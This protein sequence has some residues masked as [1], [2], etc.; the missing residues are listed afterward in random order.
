MMQQENLFEEEALPKGWISARCNVQDDDAGQRYVFIDEVWT[1]T[2]DLADS[3]MQRFVWVNIY[4]QHCAT[5]QQIS[6]GIG[7][8]LRAL[9][10]WV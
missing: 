6:S 5:Y 1:Y 2:Y 9:K 7:I 8:S 10:Y 3:E 4:K